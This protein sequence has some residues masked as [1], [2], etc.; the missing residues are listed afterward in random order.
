MTTKQFYYRHKLRRRILANMRPLGHQP[1][2]QIALSTDQLGAHD[3]RITRKGEAL[4]LDIHPFALKRPARPAMQ[5]Y[6]ATWVYWFLQAP[7]SVM[8]IT[9]EVSDGQYPTCA[10]FSFSSFTN[11]IAL[12]PDA[13]FF[14][15]RGYAATRQFMTSQNTPWHDRSDDLVWR[16]RLNN[17]G[18]ASDDPSALNAP[19][20]QHRLRMLL[21]CQDLDV[22]FK[23]VAGNPTEYEPWLHARGY[24]AEPIA[25]HSWAN[26]K[27]AIVI[28]GNTNAWSAYFKAMLMGCCVLRVGSQQGYKQ[29]YYD[30]LLPY[31]HYVP[32]RADLSDLA[33]QIDWIRS[34]DDQARTIAAAGQQVASSMTWDS[35]RKRVGKI[36]AAKEGAA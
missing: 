26:R 33:A 36:I 18:V 15:E 28:D 9:G 14:E 3:L 13:H 10:D 29:W 11:D 25:Q 5:R 20:A 19:W 27:F 4:H 31:E 23:F 35:E 22:D 24:I 8:R 6:A 30:Q 12:V 21:A 16:G 34:N 7:Q 32:V 17:T 2:L 1:K